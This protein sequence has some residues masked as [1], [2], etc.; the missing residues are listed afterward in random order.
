MKRNLAVTLL[1]GALGAAVSGASMAQTG[2]LPN[3]E[4]IGFVE[5]YDRAWNQKDVASVERAIAANYVYFSSKGGVWSR[6]RTLDMLRSPKYVL[7]SA[8]RVEVEVYRTAKTA[9]VSSRWKGSGTYDGEKFRDDQ[10]CSIV[11]AREG[12]RWKVLSEHCTE[13][14][15]P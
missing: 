3:E 13:I 14:V 5:A 11:V 10:R 7:N 12:S 15:A 8:E 1:I 2:V 9:I 6:Q 4:I